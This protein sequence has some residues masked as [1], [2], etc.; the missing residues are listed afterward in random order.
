M[1]TD[2]FITTILM[3]SNIVPIRLKYKNCSTFVGIKGIK[4]GVVFPSYIKSVKIAQSIVSP[5]MQSRSPSNAL[6]MTR[7]TKTI[8]FKKKN[9]ILFI[10]T[11][12]DFIILTSFLS[13]PFFR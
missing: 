9:I 3:I 1:L 6:I 12:I 10:I 8:A 13:I 11:N 2:S 5:M 7:M 4:S